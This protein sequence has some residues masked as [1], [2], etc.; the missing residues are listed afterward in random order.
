MRNK[1]GTTVMDR[2]ARETGALHFEA[3]QGDLGRHF[4]E[5]GDVLRSSYELAYRS[6]NPLRDGTFRKIA[7]RAK[8]PGLAVRAKTRYFAR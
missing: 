4:E 8:E 5:I 1:Y 2:I 3:R 6:T 7:I